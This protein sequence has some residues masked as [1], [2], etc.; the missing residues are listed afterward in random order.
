MQVMR[1]SP[2]AAITLQ[3]PAH[4]QVARTFTVSPGVPRPIGGVRFSADGATLYVV[5]GADTATS[6]LYR[7]AV[8]RSAT[9]QEVTA[10]GSP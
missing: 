1:A 3:D 4:F 10:L 5:G 7:M 8:T 2:A 6:A 9:T